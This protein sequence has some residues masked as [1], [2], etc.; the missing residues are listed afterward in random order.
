[1]Q[2]V[3]ADSG[4][5]TCIPLSVN[6][7]VGAGNDPGLT[8]PICWREGIQ[9]TDTRIDI[10]RVARIQNISLLA[11]CHH[12]GVKWSHFLEWAEEAQEDPL[13]IFSN[14]LWWGQNVYPPVDNLSTCMCYLSTRC[15][16]PSET[17][18]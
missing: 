4:R 7:D 9:H 17:C 3:V 8:K 18:G 12:L 13:L 10:L 1:M 16:K 5:L 11:L 6:D 15:M 2:T 14:H